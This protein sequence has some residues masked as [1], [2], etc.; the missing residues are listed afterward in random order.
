MGEG[1]GRG[2]MRK[3][4]LATAAILARAT[5]PPPLPLMTSYP[6]SFLRERTAA[7][8][9]AIPL[10]PAIPFRLFPLLISRFPY[11]LSPFPISRSSSRAS[12]EDG[13]GLNATADPAATIGR[14][15][16]GPRVV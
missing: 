10:L 14:L 3:G 1:A 5:L 2:E 13:G 9:T 8:A 16:D 11:L 4:V 7:A 6:S 15:N 12:S